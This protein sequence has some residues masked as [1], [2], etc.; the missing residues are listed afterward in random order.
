MPVGEHK[1]KKKMKTNNIE[2]TTL[3]NG[4]AVSEYVKDSSTYIEAR[5]GTE[6]AVKIKN[7]NGYKVKVIIGIDGI[8]IIDSGCLGNSPDEMGYVLDAYQET[9]IKGYRIN[10]K[11]VATFKFTEGKKAY[12]N[13]EKKMEG[14]TQ[15][16]IACRVYAEKISWQ[17]TIKELEDK[18]DQKKDKWD[19]NYVPIP[20]PVPSYP[21]KPWYQEPF[22]YCTTTT[23]IGDTCEPA[24]FTCGDNLGNIGSSVC[25]TSIDMMNKSEQLRGINTCNYMQSDMSNL[26]PVAKSSQHVNSALRSRS[27]LSQKETNPFS[28]GS[29]WGKKETQEVKEVGFDVGAFVAELVLYYAPRAGLES[30]GI[31]FK[32]LPKITKRPDAFPAADKYCSVPSGW[33]G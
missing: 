17:K 27:L 19:R 26:R 22:W 6:Y 7:H 30:L 28:L 10:N 24:S 2:L 21:V 33:T 12:A 15:G 32:K 5:N 31:E 16:V 20:Y 25:R 9:I 3:V 11:D 23:K 8:N 14:K 13:K 1:T 29:E 18:I 4:N